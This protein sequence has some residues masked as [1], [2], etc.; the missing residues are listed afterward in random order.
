MNPEIGLR[1][2]MRRWVTGVAVLTCGDWSVYHGMTVNSF[3]SISVDPPRVTVT[4]ANSTRTKYLVDE[5]GFFAVNL[6]SADQQEISERFAGRL[7]E[8]GDRFQNLHIIYGEN[9]L[10]MIEEAAA[11][12][13]C[14]VI[15]TYPMENSTL[16]V[17]AVL[18][19]RKGEDKPPL[20]YFNRSY[21]RI[22]P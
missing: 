21:H 7:A 18:S 9:H 2:V 11:H 17:G 6:L 13:E 20:V 14:M 4:L 12:L 8:E 15:H 10:P 16:Y 5:A 19:C 3:T 1:D 22:E